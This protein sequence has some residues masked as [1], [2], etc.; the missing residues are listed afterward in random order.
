M[1]NEVHMFV[2]ELNLFICQ[3][4]SLISHT[5]QI[6]ELSK[7]TMKTLFYFFNALIQ[8]PQS[9]LLVVVVDCNLSP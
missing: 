3:W 6:P 4:I 7:S 5:F 1:F 8:W 9:K 2:A